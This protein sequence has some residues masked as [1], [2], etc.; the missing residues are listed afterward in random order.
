MLEVQSPSQLLWR[1]A[2]VVGNS[3]DHL[4]VVRFLLSFGPHIAPTLRVWGPSSGEE[5]SQTRR[6]PR[7]QKENECF[8]SLVRFAPEI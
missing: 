3:D 5:V 7:I 4:E 6:L 2:I 1:R 8:H